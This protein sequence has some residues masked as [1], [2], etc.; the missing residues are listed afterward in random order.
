MAKK[1]KIPK[2]E[3]LQQQIA[4][5][6]DALQRE[7]A[8]AENIRKRAA[9]EKVDN[10]ARGREMAAEELVPLLDNLQKAFE[11]APEDIADH[12][13]VQGVLGLESQLGKLLADLGLAKIET[14]GQEFDPET[15]QAVSVEEAGGDKEIVS[16]ELQAGYTLNGKLIRVAMVKVKN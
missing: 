6:T 7:R 9:T 3:E 13:W 2:N 1:D 15:M 4:E 14:V 12:K 16:E 8:D 11:Y 5:L 10:L